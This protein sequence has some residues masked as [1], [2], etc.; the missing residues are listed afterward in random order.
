MGDAEP[1]LQDLVGVQGAQLFLE[2]RDTLAALLDTIL[3]FA[4]QA[5]LCVVEAVLDFPQAAGR[6]V[7]QA[8][9]QA[10]QVLAFST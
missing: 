10:L 2:L 8:Q 4:E 7:T 1:T 3:R 5:A 6:L 9:V